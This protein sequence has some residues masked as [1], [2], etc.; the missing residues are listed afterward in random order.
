MDNS[1]QQI[2]H[3]PFLLMQN[4]YSKLISGFWWSF[5]AHA[6]TR[7]SCQEAD[8]KLCV[9]RTSWLAHCRWEGKTLTISLRD[10]QLSLSR[11]L[12]SWSVRISNVLTGKV[13][14]SINL[15]DRDRETR[16]K[17]ELM[18]CT[19][20]YRLVFSIHQFSD[21][22]FPVLLRSGPRL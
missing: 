7:V 6:Y 20:Q 13:G 12:L 19:I 17:E 4:N 2:I 18:R 8:R 22:F 3:N 15:V 1:K 14:V 11:G 10:T 16:G 9:S 5:T 21:A